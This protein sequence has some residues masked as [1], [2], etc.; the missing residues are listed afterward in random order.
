LCHSEGELEPQRTH[1]AVYIIEPNVRND[2]MTDG[3]VESRQNVF[4]ESV[5]KRSER[6]KINELFEKQRFVDKQLKEGNLAGV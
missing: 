3:I 1:T 5:V 4:Y 6:T 2:N